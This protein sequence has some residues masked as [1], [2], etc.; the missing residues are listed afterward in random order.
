MSVDVGGASSA[1]SEPNVVPL[2]DI[3]LVLLIIFMVVTPMIQQGANVALAESNYTDNLPEPGQMITVAIKAKGEVYLDDKP[4]DNIDKLGEL[5]IDRMEE[6]Q[7]TDKK[8]LLRA[9]V[10]VEYG[11]VVDVM[12]AIRNADIELIGLVTKKR[13]SALE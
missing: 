3:L 10:D 11:R 8:V 13:A 5:I 2:C 12:N 6:L 9:D 7:R 4:V 1:K